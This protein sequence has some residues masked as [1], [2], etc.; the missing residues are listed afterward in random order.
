MSVK[1]PR[2]VLANSLAAQFEQ[3]GDDA[4]FVVMAYEDWL[5]IADSLSFCL[6]EEDLEP[7]ERDR[8]LSIRKRLRKK[9]KEFRRRQRGPE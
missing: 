2:Q 9:L 8:L 6:E 5:D 7:V 3:L 1:T 4:M